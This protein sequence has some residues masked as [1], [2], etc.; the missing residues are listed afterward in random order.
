MAVCLALAAPPAGSVHG[1]ILGITG[2]ATTTVR[3]SSGGQMIQRDFHQESVPL[4][5]PAPPLVTRSQL[6]HILSDGTVTAAGQAVAMLHAPNLTGFGPPN[7]V[8]LDLGAFSDDTATNWF[9]EGRVTEARSIVL[10]SAELGGDLVPG[11]TTL[12]RSRVLLS[13]VMLITSMDPT[14]DLSGVEVRFGL[15]VVKQAAGQ[16]SITLLEGTIALS[17]GP[18]GTVVLGSASGVF[19]AAP[20]LVVDFSGLPVLLPVVK[21]VVFA[22]VELPYEY[23]VVVGEPFKLEMR[24]D[25][26]VLT[27]PG[28]SGAA[29]VFGLP[30]GGLASVFERVKG[31][32]RGHQLATMIAQHV[33]TTGEAYLD[34]PPTTGAAFPFFFPWCGMLSLETAVVTLGGCCVVVVRGRRRRRSGASGER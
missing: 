29:S 16:P 15:S 14:K 2:T 8:G 18:G 27:I 32:D 33:D 5:R 10:H 9:I 20:P 4:T 7:D 3:Q 1:E 28:G 17:G 34:R 31:D 25:S 21:A 19:A 13:G 11:Q 30:Q 22:G 12:T 6:D 26:N 23:E 24:V